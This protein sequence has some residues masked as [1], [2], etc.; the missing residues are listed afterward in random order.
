MSVIE[1]GEQDE[2]MEE[3]GEKDMMRMTKQ[4]YLLKLTYQNTISLLRSDAGEDS[5]S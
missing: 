5:P 3:I 2:E 4:C 1:Q